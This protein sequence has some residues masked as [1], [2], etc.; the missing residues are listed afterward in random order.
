VHAIWNVVNWPDVA[1]RL[2]R[3]RQTNL[4]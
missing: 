4:V 3:A 2:E 1:A